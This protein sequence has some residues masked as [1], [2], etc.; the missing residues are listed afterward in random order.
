ME[1]GISEKTAHSVYT[2]A[3]TVNGAHA[4]DASSSI[5]TAR[6]EG[7][8]KDRSSSSFKRRILEKAMSVKKSDDNEDAEETFERRILEKVVSVKKSGDDED[9]RLAGRCSLRVKAQRRQR[10]EGIRRPPWL[11]IH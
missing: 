10:V 5:G 1:H 6:E 9:A 2:Y 3:S 8:A 4:P 11:R 7:T